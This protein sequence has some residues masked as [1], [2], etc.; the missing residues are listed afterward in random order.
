MIMETVAWVRI[1]GREVLKN[2]ENYPHDLILHFAV[3]LFQAEEPALGYFTANEVLEAYP[4]YDGDVPAL[5][6]GPNIVAFLKGTVLVL[7]LGKW[8]YSM[9]VDDQEATELLELYYAKCTVC[10]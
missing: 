1:E 9:E 6:Y 8:V 3:D 5:R 2:G 4:H 7:F 10:R